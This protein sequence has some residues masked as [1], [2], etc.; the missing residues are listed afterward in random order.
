M[1][2]SNSE[3]VDR[4]LP[5][6]LCFWRVD[7]QNCLGA[8]YNESFQVK[9]IYVS[10]KLISS[11]QFHYIWNFGESTCTQNWKQDYIIFV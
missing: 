7:R 9:L 5:L 6:S 3:R 10:Y 1:Q 8:R 4:I 11:R 2:P